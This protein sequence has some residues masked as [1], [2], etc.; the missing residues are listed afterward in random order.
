MFVSNFHS[1]QTK[2]FIL[3]FCTD[4]ILL[5]Y[6]F[7][8]FLKTIHFVAQYRKSLYGMSQITPCQLMEMKSGN[9]NYT[10]SLTSKLLVNLFCLSFAVIVLGLELMQLNSFPSLH[11]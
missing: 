2:E 8:I 6:S 1:E 4:N 7:R 10:A 5:Q 9:G 3:Y 11:H